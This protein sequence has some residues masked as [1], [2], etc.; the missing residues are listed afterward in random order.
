MTTD[1]IIDFSKNLTL[2]FSEM[3]KIGM[4]VP[5]KTVSLVS[6]IPKFTKFIEENQIYYGGG[7]RELS[8]MADFLISVTET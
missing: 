7:S 1:E 5:K 2:E 6:D 8:T 4:K 3:K